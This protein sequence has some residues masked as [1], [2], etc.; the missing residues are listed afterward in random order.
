MWPKPRPRSAGTRLANSYALFFCG[1]VLLLATL[2]FGLARHVVSNR[3]DQSLADEMATI[4][5]RADLAVFLPQRMSSSTAFRYGLFGENGLPIVG[6]VAGPLPQEG[7]SSF[8]SRETEDESDSFRALNRH[9]RAGWLV[10]ATD[11]DD[12]ENITYALFVAYGTTLLLTAL[13]ALIG[14]RWLAGVFAGRLDHLAAT[15][16]DIAQGHIQKR[17][18]LSE[19][20]DEFDRL[21]LALNYMLDRNTQLLEQ[22]RQITNNMAHDLR[23]PLTRLQQK[24]E[25][26]QWAEAQSD[27]TAMMEIVASLLRITELEEDGRTR[28]LPVMNL[29]D[30]VSE[31]TDAYRAIFDDNNKTLVADNTL[32]ALVRGDAQLLSQLVSNLLENILNHTPQAT[33]AL[34]SIIQSGSGWTLSVADNGPG[35]PEQDT[36]TIFNRFHRLQCSRNSIGHGLGL[37]LVKAIAG[38]HNASCDAQNVRPG[39]EI[40]VRFPSPGVDTPALSSRAIVPNPQGSSPARA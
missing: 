25:A 16:D 39:L 5:A 23:I 11:T 24:L 13:L 4:S 22:Q 12:L 36:K 19:N 9:V 1:A 33:T 20:A 7:W 31:V 26:G 18:P 2:A 6:N 10:V 17:M 29:Q 30:V 28:I 32:Q 40:T 35:V 34:V 15:A 14:G 21:S 3:V 38:Y 8:Q 37:S 27:T